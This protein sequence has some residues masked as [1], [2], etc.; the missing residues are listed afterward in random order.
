MRNC[1]AWRKRIPEA[2][3]GEL[4]PEARGGLDRH[5][6]SCG[7]CSGIYRALSKTV[8]QMS[9]RPAPDREEAFWEGYWDRLGRRMALETEGQE[10]ARAAGE[11]GPA[12]APL[13]RRAAFSVPRWA[14]GAAGAALFLALGIFLG[15]SIFGPRTELNPSARLTST[16]T[17]H[18]GQPGLGTGHVDPQLALRASR[19][20][21]RSRVVLLAVVNSDPRAGDFFSLGLPLQKKGS[22]ELAQEAVVLKKELRRSDPRLERLVSDLELILLQIA[23][24]KPQPDASAVEVI[25]AGIESRDIFFKINLSEVRR[26]NDGDAPGGARKLSGP[27]GKAR[28]VKTA[29]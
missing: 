3:Y 11:A 9:V 21:R 16:E 8:E 5:L 13:R 15:R 23:N 10:S 7:K 25:K 26:S 27:A 2:I 17:S 6:A 20:L 18:A 19:Y 22:E 29:V 24:L 12:D 28:G 14:F 1:R 4:E